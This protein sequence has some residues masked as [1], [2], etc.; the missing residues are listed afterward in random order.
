MAHYP[1]NTHTSTQFQ[2]YMSRGTA[3]KS[4]KNTARLPF[5]CNL[6]IAMTNAFIFRTSKTTAVGF[7]DCI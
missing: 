2:V 7:Y 4:Q 3:N 1:Y 5:S 6:V